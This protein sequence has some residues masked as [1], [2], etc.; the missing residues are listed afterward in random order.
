MFALTLYTMAD[1]INSMRYRD[2]EPPDAERPDGPIQDSDQLLRFRRAAG[3]GLR[4]AA[5][6]AGVSPG[7]LSEV[8]RANR[9]PPRRV[10]GASP[11]LLAELAKVYRCTV[12]E[13]MLNPPRRL[14]G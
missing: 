5:R 10:R 3:L 7:H 12:E 2:S 1:V 11:E 9:Q 8:E 13:L 4:A 6:Q 14:A